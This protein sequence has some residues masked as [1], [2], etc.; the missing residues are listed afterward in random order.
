[1]HVIEKFYGIICAGKLDAR[2]DVTFRRSLFKNP[3]NS[4]SFGDLA[5]VLLGSDGSS[6]IFWE[7]YLMLLFLP[8][9]CSP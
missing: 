4:W 8:L 1:V 2:F 6:V 7:S 9:N 3:L 5:S